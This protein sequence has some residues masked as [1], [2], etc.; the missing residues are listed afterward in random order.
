MSVRASGG[1]LRE[2]AENHVKGFGVLER[3]NTMSD[4]RIDFIVFRKA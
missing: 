3:F 2:S 4:K 1:R